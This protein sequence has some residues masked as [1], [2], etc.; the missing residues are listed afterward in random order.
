MQRKRFIRFNITSF[1]KNGFHKI[2]YCR[3]RPKNCK[4]YRQ[5]VS[6]LNGRKMKAF[7][8]ESGTRKDVNFHYS[9]LIH[10]QKYLTRIIRKQKNNIKI[11][12]QEV[13]NIYDIEK[14]KHFIK[15]LL[16][17]TKSIP[18]NVLNLRSSND[19]TAR[20]FKKYILFTV[21]IRY[22]EISNFYQHLEIKFKF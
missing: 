7:P 6:L 8:L 20:E 13:K 9:Y 15:K 1:K 12:K 10:Y 21:N 22:L 14:I 19:L 18:K 5:P 3:S 2:R 4:G 11:G 17:L 16:K